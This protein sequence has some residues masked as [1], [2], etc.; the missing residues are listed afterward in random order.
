[1]IRTL[2]VH[3]EMRYD[4]PFVDFKINVHSE[5]V[6]EVAWVSPLLREGANW[7]DAFDAEAQGNT[8]LVIR[9][10]TE[11]LNI[12]AQDGLGEHVPRASGAPR[13]GFLTELVLRVSG[14][15][16]VDWGPVFHK[17]F[18]G[19]LRGGIKGD[20]EWWPMLVAR[21]AKAVPGC[22]RLFPSFE[23]FDVMEA[24]AREMHDN[25]NLRLAR[26]ANEV[27]ARIRVSSPFVKDSYPPERAKEMAYE[28]LLREL[29]APIP[30]AA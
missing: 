21:Y 18:Y 2:D 14:H 9:S 10:H 27:L 16:H 17:G 7:V 8:C 29:L 24:G 30:E 13:T 12:F 20:G 5:R 28:H 25:N 22:Y 1:M 23:P 6:Q 19:W 26:A 15:S 3:Y 11:K 4:Q